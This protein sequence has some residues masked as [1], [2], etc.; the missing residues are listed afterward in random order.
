MN[1]GLGLAIQDGVFAALLSF[2]SGW[3]IIAVI[4][5]SSRRARAGL[6]GL[7]RQIQ[8][9]ELPIWMALGGAM[10]GVL[11][12]SQGLTAGLLGVSLFTVA[13]VAGQS[14]SA[15]A[16]DAN[17]WLGMERRRTSVSRVAGALIVV[18]GVGVV[19]EGFHPQNLALIALPFAAGLGLGFQQAANGR[20]RKA[21]QSAI[22]ATFLNF[23]IGTLVILA[24]KLATAPVL[25]FPDA[26]PAEWWLYLGGLVGV[27]FIAVQVVTVS[28][29]GVLALGVLLGAGQLVGSLT[30]DLMFP[31]AGQEFTWP[32]LIGVLLALVGATL[33]NVRR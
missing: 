13:V 14:L 7:F 4:F 1:G 29:I 28:R 6:L 24:V 15:I 27:T 22:A 30:I 31:V 18:L 17:G 12:M 10:G 32:R 16:I 8:L 23:A 3:L 26:F 20:I 21:A 9:R 11:V 5:A 25:G 2:S 33:V 19:A